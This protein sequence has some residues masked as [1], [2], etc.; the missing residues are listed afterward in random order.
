VPQLGFP[1][2]AIWSLA[3]F[4]KANIKYCFTAAV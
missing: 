3:K 2:L 1:I 4:H